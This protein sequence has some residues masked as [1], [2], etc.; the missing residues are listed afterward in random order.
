MAIREVVH[1][2]PPDDLP[3]R[4]LSRTRELFPEEEDRVIAALAALRAGATGAAPGG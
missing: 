4:I 2:R 3:G 1:R